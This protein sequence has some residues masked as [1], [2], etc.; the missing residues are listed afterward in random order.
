MIGRIGASGDDLPTYYL[1][2]VRVPRHTYPNNSA[3]FRARDLKFSPK[4]SRKIPE[5]KILEKNVE[6][7]HCSEHLFIL[8]SLI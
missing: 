2:S 1:R 3:I 5:K 4:N 6:F 8:S 7:E